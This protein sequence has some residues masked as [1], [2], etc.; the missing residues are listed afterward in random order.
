MVLQ[1]H[2]N[3][4]RPSRSILLAEHRARAGQARNSSQGWLKMNNAERVH[5]FPS[6][7]LWTSYLNKRL[8]YNA[9]MILLLYYVF[10]G[11]LESVLL[12]RVT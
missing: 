5:S 2:L 11:N 6:V 8:L 12:D 9:K 3:G 10:K 4:D 7:L 1:G